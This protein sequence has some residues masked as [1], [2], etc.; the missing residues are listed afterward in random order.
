MIAFLVLNIISIFFTW[1]IIGKVSIAISFSHLISSGFF[2]SSYK[3]Y[4]KNG[5]LFNFHINCKYLFKNMVENNR[6]FLKFS[7]I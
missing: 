4:D 3:Y 7:L 5:M 2:P 1:G 6:F